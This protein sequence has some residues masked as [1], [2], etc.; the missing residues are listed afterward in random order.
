MPNRRR[1]PGT[2]IRRSPVR[3]TRPVPA[4]PSAPRF[5]AISEGLW[6][7][8]VANYPGFRQKWVLELPSPAI[9]DQAKAKLQSLRIDNFNQVGD[10]ILMHNLVINR[11]GLIA[12]EGFGS[13]LARAP[14]RI[15]L[16]YSGP[17]PRHLMMAA[18]T[19]WPQTESVIIADE[20]DLTNKTIT[21]LRDQVTHLWI[22]ARRLKASTGARITYEPLVNLKVGAKGAPGTPNPGNPNYNPNARQSSSNFKRAHDG[23]DGNPGAPGEHGPTGKNAPDLTICVLEIDAMPDIILPG[24]QGGR[25]GAGGR[26]A[27]G[28]NGQRG[29]DSRVTYFLGAP[30]NCS[31][32]PGWGGYGG[33]GGNGGKGGRGGPGGDSSDV[34]IATKEDQITQLIT[35]SP[36][37][38]NNGPGAGGE[39]GPQG[40]P[41]NG[42]KGGAAGKRTGWPCSEEPH[43][44]GR[45]GER[46]HRTGD[47][48]RG[49]E[50]SPGQIKYTIITREDWELKLEAPWIESLDPFI[51]FAGDQVIIHG[52][53]FVNGTEVII[54]GRTLP[55]TFNYAEQLTFLVPQDLAGGEHLVQ[56]RTPDG[57]TSNSAP[58]SIRPFIGEI[59]KNGSP[60][61]SV[62]AG[63]TVSIIGRSFNPGAAVYAN[64]RTLQETWISSAQLNVEIPAVQGEDPGG[65]MRFIVHNPDGLE[66]NEVTIVR[67]P[68]LDSSFRAIPNGYA[69]ENFSIG[70]PTW[71]CYLE[72]FGSDEIGGE[73]ILHP[74]LTGAFYLFYEWFLS[75]P[76]HGHCSGMSATALQYFHQ[77]GSDLHSQHPSSHA[78]PPPISSQL[79]RRL[80]VTQ[81]RVLSRELVTH[82]ADQGQEGINSVEKSIRKIEEDFRDGLGESTA[83]VLCFIPS[84]SIWDVFADEQTRNAFL[85]CHCIVPTRI[86][87]P[88][89]SRSLNGAKLF[90][91]DCNRPD[92]DNLFLELFEKNGKIHFKYTDGF[93]YGYS[94]ESGF[95]LSNATLQKQLIDDVDLPFS[96]PSAT[97]ALMAFFIDLILSPAR[98]RVEDD[99]GKVLGFK[100]GKMHSDPN[101][102]YVCPWLENYLLVR[103]D[104]GLTRRRIIGEEDGKYTYMSNH[105]SGR[106]VTIK[107]A[108]CSSTTEDVVTID[109]EFAN[110]EI[111]TSEG[112]AL[113]LHLAEA[114]EDGAVRYVNLSYQMRQNEI[115]KLTLPEVLDGLNVLTPNRDIDVHLV[116]RHFHGNRLIEERSI[117]ATIAADK[118]LELPR[119]MWGDVANFQ[120][121]IL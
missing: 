121:N 13:Q 61:N 35:A 99:A 12:P 70:K 50:G 52:L 82:Y 90:I 33:R 118:R 1:F 40:A 30:V 76:G 103:V 84:G 85:R 114:L 89:S 27:N 3:V 83:R 25:G 116:I 46:G 71:G 79:M 67:L 7:L 45:D 51:G 28:G 109:S 108:L 58:F 105:P 16:P 96:G 24:Q 92:N 98:I 117:D 66:S 55:A 63:D 112:K 43:R 10:M 22:I 32:G 120:V 88:D 86:V 18:V 8:A 17:I 2:V 77:G 72:T 44:R 111:Q 87:Y 80:D 29:R 95:T 65:D 49:D 15:T 81:G 75:T 20:L 54:A 97:A 5:P 107:D 19:S 115:T 26:G 113:D 93:G 21:I 47:L 36:F 39:P 94:S 53:H 102:G 41:G 9:L 110:V 48:G 31:S 42:G 60:T 74:I 106:S 62:H 73:L 38:L 64:D 78:D 34:T 100:D 101:L 104:A 23:G 11:P 37:I 59:L 119:G 4:R 6:K 91:Y 56:V 57:D 68:S 14:R 69:F